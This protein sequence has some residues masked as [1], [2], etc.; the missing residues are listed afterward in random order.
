MAVRPTKRVL[1][2]AVKHIVMFDVKEG[3]SDAALTT[4]KAALLKLPTQIP[5]IVDHELGQDL[6]L[7]S[8][9]THP[10]G[11]NRSISWMAT[12][13]SA[14]SYEAYQ[15]HPDHV[16]FLTLLKPLVL[17]GSRAAI[18]YKIEVTKEQ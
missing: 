8:G 14:E 11:K 12:F 13:D 5:S 18:Q 2:S 10:A 7:E 15:V 4:L 6:R 1:A 9:Q 17:P 3:T 16:A